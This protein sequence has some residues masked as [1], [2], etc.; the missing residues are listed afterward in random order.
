MRNLLSHF[1]YYSLVLKNAFDI[2]KGLRVYEHI[3]LPSSKSKKL[4]KISVQFTLSVMSDSLRPLELQHMPGLPVHHQ[5]PKL[6]QTHVHCIGDA[7]QT[8]H[9]LLSPS[10]PA[11][12]LSEHQSLFK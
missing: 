4:N 9:A 3:F 8:S 12:N 7:I 1:H 10:P 11:F 5:L 6:T 2:L